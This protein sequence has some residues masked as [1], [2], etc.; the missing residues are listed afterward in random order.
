MGTAT[1]SACGPKTV[2]LGKVK[3]VRLLKEGQITETCGV[4]CSEICV[5]V[6]ANPNACKCAGLIREQQK[7]TGGTSR[8][9]MFFVDLRSGFLKPLMEPLKQHVSLMGF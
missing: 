7:Q 1:K 4:S 6:K 3:K 8:A 9:G 2:R 5:R